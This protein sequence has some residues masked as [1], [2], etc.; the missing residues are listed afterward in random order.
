M[1]RSWLIPASLRRAADAVQA[2][3]KTAMD[4]FTKHDAHVY[5]LLTLYRPLAA[6]TRRL[7][8]AGRQR[9][10]PPDP[11][12]DRGRLVRVGSHRPG[13]SGGDKV[14]EHAQTNQLDL[15]SAQGSAVRRHSS[16]SCTAGDGGR[17][18]TQV[19][20]PAQTLPAMG[21]QSQNM[22]RKAP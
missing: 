5:D 19:H 20:M 10:N 7:E 14:A 18:A 3:L 12:T 6:G 22:A 17:D 4:C 16:I 13:A 2:A 11:H 21:S 15:G 8:E 1:S 9:P